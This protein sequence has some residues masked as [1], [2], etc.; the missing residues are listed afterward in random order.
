MRHYPIA[1]PSASHDRR[2]VRQP[3][4]IGLA[5]VFYTPLLPTIIAA[6]WFSPADAAYLGAANLAGYLAGAP[7]SLR[8]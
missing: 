6:H 4:R 7:S 3:G 5:R 2:Y 1:N 8:R